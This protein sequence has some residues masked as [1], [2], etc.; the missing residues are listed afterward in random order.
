MFLFCLII[1]NI[2]YVYNK[3]DLDL[4]YMY[5]LDLLTFVVDLAILVKVSFV[6]HLHCFRL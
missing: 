6:D 2:S 5:D 1:Q 4:C 3:Y